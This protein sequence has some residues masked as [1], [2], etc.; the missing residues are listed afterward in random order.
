MLI[1]RKRFLGIQRGL[2]RSGGIVLGL[3][4]GGG[5][6][7]PVRGGGA[8]SR[9][10]KEMRVVQFFFLLVYFCEEYDL[11]LRVLFFFLIGR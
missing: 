6:R 8:L 9:F 10:V 2:L 7:G 3:G 11:Q 4:V 1:V 5:G